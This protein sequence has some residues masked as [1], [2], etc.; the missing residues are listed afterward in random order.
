MKKRALFDLGI[1]CDHLLP[2]AGGKVSRL[3]KRFVGVRDGEIVEVAPFRSSH[4]AASRKFI[5]GSGQV[6]LPSFVNGH[7]HL[8][9]SLF[10]GIEDDVDFHTWLFERILPLEAEMVSAK[11]VREGTEL[12]ALECIRFGV[13]TV[14][15]M[16]F[17]TGETAATLDKAGMRAIVS[18]SMAKFPLPEDK[19]VGTD[20]L[21]VVEKLRR[22]YSEHPRI[23]I[24]LAPHAPYSCDDELLLKVKDFADR[25]GAPIHIHVSET[26]KEVA[27][28]LQEFGITP[29]ER[30]N[31]LGLLRPRTLCAH[32][33]HLN[34]N[35]REI[36]QRSGASVLYNPDSNMKLGSGIAPVA[37][38][39][40]RGIPLAFGTD[41]SASNNDLSL[42]GA[43][44]IGTKLQK[45]A[46][47][48]STAFTA[49]EALLAATWG[50]AHALGLG[51]KVGSIEVGKRADF[52]LVDFRQPHLQPVHDPVS[53]L[54]YAA[55]GLEVSATV[56]DGKVLFQN[57]KFTT[58]DPKA[59]YSRVEGWRKK[60]QKAVARLRG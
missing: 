46:Q 60:I 2:M 42:F 12:A 41:G 32:C 1:F 5:D 51:D 38:Y 17:F 39:V 30:L 58:L 34:E 53:H 18:Q 36:M 11:F 7:S 33:V 56:C 25:H 23:E 28:S 19:V 43:M 52:I 55:Q 16:Y 21:A 10:R 47:G 6:C 3:E 20:K 13:T 44:D 48:N 49:A 57:G 40:K 26:A 15:E 22:K 8:A 29:V 54:V 37:D 31:R 45:L 35:D 59:V 4:K 27:D 50:G 14:N 24:G 9:M